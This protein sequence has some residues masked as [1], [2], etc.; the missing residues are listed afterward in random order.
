[1]PI[2]T[3]SKLSVTSVSLSVEVA[4]KSYGSGTSSFMSLTAK[5]PDSGLPL[6]DTVTLIDGG[7]EMYLIAVETLMAGRL[8]TEQITEE[9]YKTFVGNATQRIAKVREFL[10]K[11]VP[12]V[13]EVAMPSISQP[14]SIILIK[15]KITNTTPTIVPKNSLERPANPFVPLEGDDFSARLG[16]L[17]DW[18]YDSKPRDSTR[19]QQLVKYALF[20]VPDKDKV[21]FETNGRWIESRWRTEMLKLTKEARRARLKILETFAAGASPQEFYDWAWKTTEEV[22]GPPF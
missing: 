18:V 13:E 22:W 16:H 20:L 15:T 12:A 14:S 21:N 4:D 19:G 10:K 7:L 5:A 11:T 2:P 8:A 6:E 9:F 3:V 1:M 17:E